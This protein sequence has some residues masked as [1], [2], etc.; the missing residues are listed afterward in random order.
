[1]LETRVTIVKLTLLYL[2]DITTRSTCLS[3]AKSK[4]LDLLLQTDPPTVKTGWIQ[5]V[6]HIC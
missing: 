2:S 1:M 4:R 6:H 3:V 5:I